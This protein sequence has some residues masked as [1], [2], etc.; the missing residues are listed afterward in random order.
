MEE[1][2]TIIIATLRDVGCEFDE[3]VESLIHFSAA[4]VVEACVRCLRV[5]LPDFDSPAAMPE[6]MSARYRMCST[7]ANAC[8][9][10]GYQGEIGYQTFLYSSV[11]EWRK[12]LMFLLEKLPREAVQAADEPTGARV[13]LNRRVATELSDALTAVWTPP[14]CKKQGVVWGKNQWRRESGAGCHGY[15]TID[16]RAPE[17]TGDITIKF[18]KDLRKYYTCH[19]DYV[20]AQPR[21]RRDV[22]ASLLERNASDV[23]AQQDW[24][25]EWNTHGLTSRLTEEEYRAR[26]RQRL[27]KKLSEQL[28]SSLQQGS[29][30]ASAGLGAATDLESVLNSFTDKLSSGFQ[31]KGSRFQHTEKLQFAK[32]EDAPMQVEEATEEEL[33]QRREEEVTALQEQLAQLTAQLEAL[34]LG[35]K[36]FSSGI[37]HMMEREL[38]Q[39]AQNKEN[40]EAYK[41][42]KTTHDLLPNADE[43]IT[44]LKELI[45]NSANR[46]AKLSAK[47][48]EVRAPLLEQ[49]RALRVEIEGRESEEEKVLGEVARMRGRMKEVADETRQKENLYKQLVSEYEQLS[50]GQSRVAYTRRIMEI[51]A[52]IQ[53]QK[54]DI[55]RILADT[56]K[57]QKEINH[58]T[59]KLDRVFTMTDE[60]V[61]KDARKDESRRQ[62]YKLLAALRENCVKVVDAIKDTGQTKREQKDL[63]DQIDSEAGKKVAA[64]LKSI[65]GDLQQMRNENSQLAAQLKS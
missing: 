37:Q 4:M 63:E 45:Q 17:G 58:L 28:R 29:A 25:A 56:R 16:I 7:L 30:T 62:A 59:G 54:E 22:L 11:K 8:Q 10:L 9:G 44:K 20:P 34:E 41:V 51:V 27:Q 60:Q 26:K 18:P 40:E 61:Y 39:N 19:M 36:K 21:V 42:K 1:V 64:N 12:L 32:E 50:K 3:N 38:Q 6:V 43:N 52:N 24:E 15:H 48:E 57:V 53:K 33:Q 65:E 46:L 35:R 13:I 31:G 23:A 47:W 14:F 2:D 55:G 5:I 49:Y